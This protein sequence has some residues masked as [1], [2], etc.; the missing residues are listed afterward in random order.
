MAEMRKPG[1]V[2]AFDHHLLVAAGMEAVPVA[3]KL[4]ALRIELC[5]AL[6]PVERIDLFLIRA[7]VVV[8]HHVGVQPMLCSCAFAIRASNSARLP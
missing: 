3:R 1:E 6:L 7:G 8:D 5:P 4:A 2:L